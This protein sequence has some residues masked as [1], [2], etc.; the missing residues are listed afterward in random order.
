[1]FQVRMGPAGELAVMSC[2]ADGDSMTS[3]AFGFVLTS[4]MLP[5]EAETLSVALGSPTAKA[6]ALA[7]CAC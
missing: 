3:S 4:T 1:M 7:T 2:G 5:V 6:I